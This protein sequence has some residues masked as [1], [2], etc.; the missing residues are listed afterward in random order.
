MPA[1]TWDYGYNAFGYR[2]TKNRAA[3]AQTTRSLYSPGGVLLADTNPG[4][5]TLDTIYVWNEGQL[6]GL[7]RGGQVY[8]VHG[9]HLGRP[10]A[11]TNAAKVVVWRA[12]NLAWDRRVTVDTIGGL[13]IGFPGQRYDAEA[14]SWYNVFRDYDAGVGR[15][16][17]SDPIGIGGG[18]NTYA[19]ALG[20]PIS[21]VDPLGLKAHSECETNEILAYARVSAR[22]PLGFVALLINHFPLGI[23]DFKGRNGPDGDTFIVDGHTL[24]SA[25]FGNYI[26]GYSAA[27]HSSGWVAVGLM[28]AGGAAVQGAEYLILVGPENG[29]EWN[30][31]MDS[32]ADIHDGAERAMSE[33]WNDRSIG[34]GCE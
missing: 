30:W 5:T 26:A 21:K 11:V 12:H 22:V 14:G 31:D 10:E 3:P 7:I 15:Y 34:C 2:A 16:L 33:I 23:L 8:S 24:N 27:Y 19:Y 18:A 1:G 25:Q 20:N 9:D 28:H 29:A 32:A 4:S 13:D 6:V 17:E